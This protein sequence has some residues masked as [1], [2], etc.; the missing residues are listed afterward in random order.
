MSVTYSS[1][2]SLCVVSSTD[3]IEADFLIDGKMHLSEIGFAIVDHDYAED[4]GLL[5]KIP[6]KVKA[7]EDQVGHNEYYLSLKGYGESYGD[8]DVLDPAEMLKDLQEAPDKY[9]DLTD[10]LTELGFEDLEFKIIHS[11]SAS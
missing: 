7:L 5:D 9:R 11:M 10:W 3:K 6:S 1:A 2:V 8:D 4:I